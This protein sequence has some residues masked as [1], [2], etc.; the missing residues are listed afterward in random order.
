MN[1]L[2]GIRLNNLGPG[3]ITSEIDNITDTLG[4]F[5]VGEKKN[6]F[7]NI[8]DTKSKDGF[9]GAIG[10]FIR[11]ATV[12]ET[13]AAIDPNAKV[14]SFAG[15]AGSMVKSLINPLDAITDLT[16]GVSIIAR[17][18]QDGSFG[19]STMFEAATYFGSAIPVLGAAVDVTKLTKVFKEGQKTVG[20]IGDL[21]KGFTS[22]FDAAKANKGNLHI[23]DDLL[24]GNLS[25]IVKADY[26][27]D[28][29]N[30][31][32]KFKDGDAFKEMTMAD[33]LKQVRKKDYIKPGIES[34]LE[35]AIKN[36]QNN[37]NLQI[38]DSLKELNA[39]D[40]IRNQQDF[41]SWKTVQENKIKIDGNERKFQELIK[42]TDAEEIKKI[43]QTLQEYNRNNKTSFSFESLQ[44]MEKGHDSWN[45]SSLTLKDLEIRVGDRV[46]GSKVSSNGQQRFNSIEQYSAE[47]N[48][49]QQKLKEAGQDLAD[50][51]KKITEQ[52]KPIV[53]GSMYQLGKFSS[54]V[55]ENA[56]KPFRQGFSGL[57]VPA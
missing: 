39:K 31:T 27:E 55:K 43:N 44:K 6:L 45:T 4:F 21:N 41:H 32:V 19:I 33:A 48:F 20:N 26:W 37:F 30:L 14:D 52:A 49:H 38:G 24:T 17:S 47:S 54:A 5:D 10:D 7:S 25:D 42:T 3:L 2:R 1:A 13:F 57:S 50:E 23:G 22:A 12:G 11:A 56:I 46:L 8:T 53:E 9:F 35:K 16:S 51:G 40:L 34:D 29:K 36:T 18:L 28:I 15:I